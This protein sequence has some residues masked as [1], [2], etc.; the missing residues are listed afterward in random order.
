MTQIAF[1]G[2]GNMATSI[3]GGLIKQGDFKAGLIHVADPGAEQRQKLVKQFGVT[4]HEENL[5]AIAKADVVIMAVKPQVM[6]DVLAPLH[7]TLS[8]RQPLIISIAAGIS[9][10]ALRQWSGCKAIVRCMPNTPALLSKGATGLF[11]SPDVHLD[12]RNLADSLLRSVG[13]TVWVKNEAEIDAVTAVSGSGPAYYFLLMEAMI[14]AGQKL[15]LSRETAT[16]LTLQ[17]A[18]G[19]AEMALGSDVDPAELRRRVTSPGGTTER[20]IGT[21][22]AAHLRDIVD[23]AMSACQ[24]RAVELSKELS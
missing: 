10:D 6:K 5:E 22:E 14:D 4:T 7:S 3:I 24:Q 18:L 9:M 1:I 8:S 15:G 19:A 11:A 2:G 16:K 13:L 21:F 17:T 12:Q 20:A 23:A